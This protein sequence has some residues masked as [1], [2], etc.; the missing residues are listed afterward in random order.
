MQ[1]SF[2][3]SLTSFGIGIPRSRYFDHRDLCA[4]RPLRSCPLTGKGTIYYRYKYRRMLICKS[5]M[6]VFMF[7]QVSYHE[8]ISPCK[9]W[10]YS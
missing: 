9:Q 5:K 4:D 2:N 7:P 3:N 6:K 1:K 8:T 10:K